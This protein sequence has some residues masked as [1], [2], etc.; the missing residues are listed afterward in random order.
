VYERSVL[1]RAAVAAG[2]AAALCA[3]AAIAASPA[4][5][6]ESHVEIIVGTAP[7]RGSDENPYLNSADT[8]RLM[9]AQQAELTSVLRAVGLA[10]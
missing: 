4:W 6:S 5:K 10:K 2:A 9:D 3:A 1:R 8:R 7:G